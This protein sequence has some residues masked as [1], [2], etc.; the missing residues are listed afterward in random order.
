MDVFSVG[1]GVIRVFF[2]IYGLFYFDDAILSVTE[3]GDY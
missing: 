1:P 3:I 2:Y